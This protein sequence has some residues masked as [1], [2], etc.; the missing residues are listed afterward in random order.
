MEFSLENKA[1]LLA[2]EKKQERSKVF[3][4]SYLSQVVLK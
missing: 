2:R 3:A 4:P 1:A